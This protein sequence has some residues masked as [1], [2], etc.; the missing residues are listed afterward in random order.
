VRL[1]DAESGTQD[2]VL[3]GHNGP[4]GTV[5]F[6]RD[7]TKLASVSSDGTARVWALDLDDLIKI[8]NRHVTRP[9]TDEECQQYLHVDHCPQP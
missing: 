7:G 1:W 9:L 8:A 4:V 2:L 3:R 5:V 6:S